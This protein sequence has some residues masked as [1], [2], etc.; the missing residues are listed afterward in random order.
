VRPFVFGISSGRDPV[1][2]AKV[3]ELDRSQKNYIKIFAH[4]YE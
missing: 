4:G 3:H 2:L 1:T